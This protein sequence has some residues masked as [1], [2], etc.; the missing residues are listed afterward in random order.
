MKFDCTVLFEA[1]LAGDLDT[2]KPSFATTLTRQWVS[3]IL[4]ERQ[5]HRQKALC[6]R[7]GQAEIPTHGA[8][9]WKPP[10]STSSPGM[11]KGGRS[12]AEVAHSKKTKMR[13]PAI[14]RVPPRFCDASGD[15]VLRPDKPIHP[16]MPRHMLMEGGCPFT[17]KHVK[18]RATVDTPIAARPTG[19]PPPSIGV[20]SVFA[21]RLR[22][23]L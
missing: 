20:R 2:G 19:R 12:L 5:A 17:E 6:A 7:L 10:G 21:C 14:V 4:R 16:Q 3:M 22:P 8:E 1:F 9:H 18:E 13:R 23:A 11:G 15:L